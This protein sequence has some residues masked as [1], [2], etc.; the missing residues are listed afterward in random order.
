VLPN[1][2]KVGILL[3]EFAHLAGV[4]DEL[5]ADWAVWKMFGIRVGRRD[6]E[7]GRNLESVEEL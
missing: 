7:W 1:H 2:H 5:E 6:S 3:H 4:E